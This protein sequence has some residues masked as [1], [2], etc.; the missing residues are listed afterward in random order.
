M[1]RSIEN[2]IESGKKINLTLLV[3]MIHLNKPT[4]VESV[5]GKI[6]LKLYLN[7]K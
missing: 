2:N 7:N 5:L 3:K 4:T 6:L 1:I